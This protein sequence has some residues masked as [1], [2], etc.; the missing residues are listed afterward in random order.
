MNISLYFYGK[1]DRCACD[2][3]LVRTGIGALCLRCETWA[4]DAAEVD[5]LVWRAVVACETH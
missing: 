1:C 2:A 5:V 4:L 3:R